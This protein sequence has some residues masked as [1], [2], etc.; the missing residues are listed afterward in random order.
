V[1]L[2]HRL[3]DYYE[4]TV[5]VRHNMGAG[6]IA[7]SGVI[8]RDAPEEPITLI[9]PDTDLGTVEPLTHDGYLPQHRI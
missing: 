3:D 6:I 7:A 5:R 2:S 1:L 8:F 4:A 9:V